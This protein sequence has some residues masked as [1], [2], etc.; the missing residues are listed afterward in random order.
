MAR[1]KSLEVLAVELP[2]R[3]PFKHAAAERTTSSS[4]FLKCT[5]DDGTVGFGES[6]RCLHCHSEMSTSVVDA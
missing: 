3:R 6:L 4:L 2:F 5:L 1:L